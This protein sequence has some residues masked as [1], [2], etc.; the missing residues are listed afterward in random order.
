MHGLLRPAPNGTPALVIDC[1]T[2]YCVGVGKTFHLRR[3]PALKTGWTRAH[4]STKRRVY[5][6]PTPVAGSAIREGIMLIIHS[7]AM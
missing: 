6:L 1:T 5:K 2:R 4:T 3:Q 7:S